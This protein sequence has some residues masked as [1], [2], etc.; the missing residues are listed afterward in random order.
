MQHSVQG[1]RAKDIATG[2]TITTLIFVV[3]V[4]VP[5]LGFFF[6]IFIPL[7]ILFYRMKLGRNTAM[8]VPVATLLIITVTLGGISIDILFFAELFLLGEFIQV[9]ADGLRRYLE[10][11]Y[12]LFG[13]DETVLLDQLH[14]QI[15]SA[16]LCH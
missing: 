6:S 12:Q 5:L 13:G 10:L 3:S 14:N 4:L 8:I 11:V 7:P 16:T 15:L 9:P 2:I 1:D